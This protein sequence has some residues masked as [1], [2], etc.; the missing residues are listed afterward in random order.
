MESPVMLQVT[1]DISIV[2]SLSARRILNSWKEIAEYMRMRVRT[3]QRYEAK[4]GLPIHRVTGRSRSAVFAFSEEIDR[5]LFAS[6][7]RSN[8]QATR[9]CQTFSSLFEALEEHVSSCPRCAATT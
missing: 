4:L 3:V 5:W 9:T 7:M 8:I 2:D 1:R 6:P